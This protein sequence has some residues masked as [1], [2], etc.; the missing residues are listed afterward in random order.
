MKEITQAIDAW[1]EGEF[2]YTKKLWGY[3]ELMKKADQ[4]IPVTINER[5]QVSLNDIY[6]LI[7]WIRLISGPNNTNLLDGN[8]WSFGLQEAPVK[9]ITLRI[10]VAH[11]ISIGE[12]FIIDFL[13]AFPGQFTIDGYSIVSVNRKAITVDPDHEAIYL[14]ELGATVYEKHRFD[15]NIYAL[16]VM[17]EFIPCEVLSPD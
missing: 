8:D 14:T 7:T 10:I 6:E 13:K 11:K 5:K 17:V 9:T 12:D 2:R 3:S 1:T 15:W 16:E 4:V